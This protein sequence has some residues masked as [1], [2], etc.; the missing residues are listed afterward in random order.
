MSDGELLTHLL[1]ADDGVLST[2]NLQD[3]QHDLQQLANLSKERPGK[4]FLQGK[5]DEE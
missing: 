2:T 4:E 1:F 3:L 5:V